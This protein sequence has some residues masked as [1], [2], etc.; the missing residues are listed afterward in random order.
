MG[1]RQ[2]YPI[3]E[4]KSIYKSLRIFHIYSITIIH[5]PKNSYVLGNTENINANMTSRQC[6]PTVLERNFYP[7]L[8]DTGYNKSEFLIEN[9]LTRSTFPTKI[10]IPHQNCE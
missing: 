6:I 2:K 10:L 5:I 9:D 3:R 4:A 1:S 7:P 8:G